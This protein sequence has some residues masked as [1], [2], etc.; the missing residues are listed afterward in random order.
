MLAQLL[1]P[2]CFLTWIQFLPSRCPE[3]EE[4]PGDLHHPESF[5]ASGDVRRHGGRNPGAL[6]PTDP[7]HPQHLQEHEQ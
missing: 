1:S 3:H 6:L 2:F 5:A 7:P 4:P